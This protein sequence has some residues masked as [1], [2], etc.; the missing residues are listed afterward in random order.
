MSVFLEEKAL[1]EEA[2]GDLLVRAWGIPREKADEIVERARDTSR[3][4]IGVDLDGTLAKNF[5][6]KF[7][8]TRIGDPVPKMVEKVREAIS[9][10]KRVKVFTARMSDPAGADFQRRL[11][12][13]WTMRNVGYSLEATC[14][15]DQYC[16]E[17][18]D[19]RAV[20][21]ERDRGVFL[22]GKQK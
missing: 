12:G 10:G 6:G 4:W 3:R 15:K 14:V 20:G 19:D 2:L 11:I 8:P 13:D 9:N 5:E 17:I 22:S 7:D 16:E 18:W 1:R 21:V